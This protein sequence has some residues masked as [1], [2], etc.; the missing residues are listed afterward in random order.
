MTSITLTW[1]TQMDNRVCPTCRLLNGNT[2]TFIVGKDTFPTMLKFCGRPVWDIH[3]GSQAH[4]DNPYN[5]RCHITSKIDMSDI[6][7]RMET[8]KE[9]LTQASMNEGETIISQ[10]GN[11]I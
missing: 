10:R 4:G 9:Q 11:Y 3:Q 7:T 1:H 8:L 5:C 2:W 6:K